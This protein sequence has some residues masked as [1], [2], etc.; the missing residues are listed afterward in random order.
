ML[1]EPETLQVVPLV[2]PSGSTRMDKVA[3]I[4]SRCRP[5]RLA[6]LP[7]PSAW[8]KKKSVVGT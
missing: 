6:A 8:G 1:H 4:H 7:H 3:H 5:P 2:M